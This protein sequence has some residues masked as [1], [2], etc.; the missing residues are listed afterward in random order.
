MSDNKIEVDKRTFDTLLY[1]ALGVT[2]QDGL[3]TVVT[4]IVD[5]AF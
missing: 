5:K 1:F 2:L 3:E 4:T